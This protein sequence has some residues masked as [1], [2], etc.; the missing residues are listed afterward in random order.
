MSVVERPGPE[1]TV[2]RDG[3]R[4]TLLAP[5]L[6]VALEL[7]ELPELR[8]KIYIDTPDSER[9]AIRSVQWTPDVPAPSLGSEQGRVR[10]DHDEVLYAVDGLRTLFV[11]K[12]PQR[13]SFAAMAREFKAAAAWYAF[14]TQRKA[15]HT[16]MEGRNPVAVQRFKSGDRKGEIKWPAKMPGAERLEI[17]QAL[18]S[19]A[20]LAATV[21]DSHVLVQA[22]ARRLCAR[23]S[24]ADADE[25]KLRARRAAVIDLRTLALPLCSYGQP[26]Y[27][28]HTTTDFDLALGSIDKRLDVFDS[29][30]EYGFAVD[31]TAWMLPAKWHDVQAVRQI[32][33][34]DVEVRRDVHYAGTHVLIEHRRLVQVIDERER[35]PH[36]YRGQMWTT[37]EMLRGEKPT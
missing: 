18:V 14:V 19:N 12:E 10:L 17:V 37:V 25:T 11:M 21:D 26:L 31:S 36:D 8:P 7:A 2:Y 34:L 9:A 3:G 23:L 28:S 6:R 5:S 30:R 32:K 22:A 1:W 29:V 13:D 35:E 4:Y 24:I 15:E 16:A 33:V 27:G 20:E